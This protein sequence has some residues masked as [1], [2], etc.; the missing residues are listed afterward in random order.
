MGNEDTKKWVHG[1]GCQCPACTVKG[2]T[3][4][5]TV[6]TKDLRELARERV[7][8]QVLFDAGTDTAAD[9]NRVMVLNKAMDES[10]PSLVQEVVELREWATQAR[11]ALEA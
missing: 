9:I 1:A 6:S 11:K 2:D 7:E 5:A 8:L 4:F 10:F 3:N